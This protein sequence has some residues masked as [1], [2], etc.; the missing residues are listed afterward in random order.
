MKIIAN[1]QACT[2]RLYIYRFE[3]SFTLHLHESST[4]LNMQEREHHIFEVTTN[5]QKEEQIFEDL[6]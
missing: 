3:N 4:L 6:I 2:M 1:M 5:H